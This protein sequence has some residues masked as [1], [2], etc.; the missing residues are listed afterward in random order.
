MVKSSP[1][2]GNVVPSPGVVVLTLKPDIF[3]AHYGMSLVLT[4][5]DTDRRTRSS[6]SLSFHTHDHMIA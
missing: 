5:G 6:E 2:D 3:S 4:L 1:V